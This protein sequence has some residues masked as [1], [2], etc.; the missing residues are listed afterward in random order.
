MNKK[1]VFL[2]S[3]YDFANS[4][5]YIN[6]ALYF[7]QWI[8]I[9]AGLADFWYNAIFALAT[10]I[11]LFTAPILAARTDLRGGRKYWLNISTV[12]TALSY[13]LVAVLAA[14]GSPVLLIA[15]FFLIGQYFYQLSFIFYNPMLDEITDEAHKSRVSGIGNFAGSI[16]FVAGILITLPFAGSRITPLLVSV[17]VFFIFAL[18]MMIFFKESKKVIQPNTSQARDQVRSFIKKAVVFFGASAAAPMLVAFFFYNDALLTISNNYSIYLERVFHAPDAT[19]SLLLMAI[20]IMSAIGSVIAGWLGD[21]IGMLKT[22][23]IILFSWIIAIPIL[24][25]APN[26]YVAALLSPVMGLLIG[27]AWTTSRAYLAT[28]LTKE[29]MGYGFSFYTMAERFATFVGPLTWGGIIWAMGTHA[30]SY[31][32]AVGVMTIFTIIGFCIL[33]FWKR[34][35]VQNIKTS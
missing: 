4:V 20:L 12:C 21:K 33:H 3:L 32:V 23:K 7:S 17:P 13:G 16:G 1:Q 11:L 8:V 31:R 5:V 27:S 30:F 29:N 15:L 18:P 26:F 35:A 34:P 9:N 19:K 28:V 2:W 24:A 22:L 25:L 14:M 6:F 10:V